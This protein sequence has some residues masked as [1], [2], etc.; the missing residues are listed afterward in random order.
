M[1]DAPPPGYTEYEQRVIDELAAC[2]LDRSGIAVRYVD[3]L[4]EFEIVISVSA[5]PDPRQFDCL[6]DTSVYLEII[7]EDEALNTAYRE[8]IEKRLKTSSEL[9]AREILKERGLLEGLPTLQSAGSYEAY[10]PQLEKHCG[11]AAGS[12]LRLLGT[13]HIVY[14]PKLPPGHDDD[15]KTMCL[16]AGIKLGGATYFGFI[17]NERAAPAGD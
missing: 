17:G 5:N 11:F 10:L 1:I 14:G 3:Y 9:S 15:N 2:G 8:P 7:F 16:L 12:V 13:D 6:E 4:Q